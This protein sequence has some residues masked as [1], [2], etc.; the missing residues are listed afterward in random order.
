LAGAGC[1]GIAGLGYCVYKVQFADAEPAPRK[2]E[3]PAP[4]NEPVSGSSEPADG[5]IGDRN[6]PVVKALNDLLKPDNED[7]EARW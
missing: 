3:E 5:F 7:V 1:C 6:D 4:G 2:D